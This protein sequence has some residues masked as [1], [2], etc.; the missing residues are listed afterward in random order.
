MSTYHHAADPVFVSTNSYAALPRG[1]AN[2]LRII[3]AV[4][5]EG[6][7]LIFS[8]FL[9][10]SGKGGLGPILCVSRQYSIIQYYNGV[11]DLHE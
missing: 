8:A 3:G 6:C 9:L 2:I 11:I 1:V 7:A 4:C 10:F 5:A